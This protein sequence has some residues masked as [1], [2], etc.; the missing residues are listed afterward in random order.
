MILRE[1]GIHADARPARG[2]RPIHDQTRCVLALF[3]RHLPRVETDGV[4]KLSVQLSAAPETS[5]IE[6]QLGVARVPLAVDPGPFYE[7]PVAG[8]KRLSLE[9]LERGIERARTELGWPAGPFAAAARAVRAANLTNAWCFDPKWAPG[10]RFRAYVHCEHEP[11]LFSGEL[12]I[13]SREGA[14]VARATV[15]QEI[16][17]EFCFVPRLGKVKW[18]DRTR[19]VLLDKRGHATCRALE[20][21]AGSA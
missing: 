5:D 8:K 7:L 18:L 9:L 6:T 21:T 4:W 14:V 11:E 3:E 15:L 13:E 17:S 20:V 12:R 19:V 10:R 16:P 2:Q 1:F